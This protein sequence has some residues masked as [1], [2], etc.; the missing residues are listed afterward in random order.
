MLNYSDWKS[1]PRPLY[2]RIRLRELENVCGCTSGRRADLA[3]R[4]PRR[5]MKTG[6][7]RFRHSRALAVLLVIASCLMQLQG[8]TQLL[9]AEGA[10]TPLARQLQ[11]LIDQPNW[12]PAIWGIHIV[13]LKDGKVLF[14][15]NARKRFLPA[16][17]M[18]LLIGAAALDIFGLDFRFETP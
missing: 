16:S 9:R 1:M 12:E 10:A 15:S 14:S 3:K 5:R 4:I 11:Q 13:S 7:Y 18:K 8:R 17:N 2:R 6:G